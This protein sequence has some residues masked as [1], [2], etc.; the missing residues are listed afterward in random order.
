LSAGRFLVPMPDREPVLSAEVN[1]SSKA[2]VAAEMASDLGYRAILPFALGQAVCRLAAS[3]TTNSFEGDRFAVVHNPGDVQQEA[4]QETARKKQMAPAITVAT[5]LL[6]CLRRVRIEY[7]KRTSFR[8]HRLML[9]LRGGSPPL[10][11]CRCGWCLL[12]DSLVSRN[13]VGWSLPRLSSNLVC[14]VNPPGCAH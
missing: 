4:V 14:A 8:R 6:L 1:G 12:P 5:L 13:G 2:A 11:L 9:V 10:Q 7:A 3:T